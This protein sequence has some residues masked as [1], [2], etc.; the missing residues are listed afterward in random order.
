MSGT[1]GPQRR[2]MATSWW[3]DG[4]CATTIQACTALIV[5]SILS[6]LGVW[7]FEI[8]LRRLSFTE[9]LYLQ[10]NDSQLTQLLTT[11]WS[12]QATVTALPIAV[13]AIGLQL[14]QRKTYGMRVTRHIMMRARPFSPP[15]KIV[16]AMVW[17]IINYVNVAFGWL[18]GALFSLAFSGFLVLSL[19]NDGIWA[20]TKSDQVENEIEDM[21]LRIVKTEVAK[22]VYEHHGDSLDAFDPPKRASGKQ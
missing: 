9:W 1:A 18:S 2:D 6:A 11:L 14:S 5:G 22:E 20:L 15:A 12:I 13:L 7:I 8:F 10:I 17:M 21:Y 16:A 4:R 19:V 3:R